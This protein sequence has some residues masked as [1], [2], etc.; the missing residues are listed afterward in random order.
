VKVGDYVYGYSDSKG[1]TCQDFK[2]GEAKW[3][4]KEKLGKGSLTSAEGLLY[5]RQEDKPGTVALVAA[6]PEGYREAGRFAP[7]DRSDKQSWSHPVIAGGRL[8]LR[9]Q[10]TLLCYDLRAAPL[11]GQ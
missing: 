5:L 2:S 3:Q 11:S 9:D 1:W 6:T 7:P 4:E 10:D 8:Y